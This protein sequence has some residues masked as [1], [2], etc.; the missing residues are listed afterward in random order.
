MAYARFE[1]EPTGNDRNYK[2]L[3]GQLALER[4]S[5]RYEDR[6]PP[7]DPYRRNPP[8]PRRYTPPHGNRQTG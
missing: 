8:S 2:P 4:N 5:R 3:P 1:D 6:Y 7:R